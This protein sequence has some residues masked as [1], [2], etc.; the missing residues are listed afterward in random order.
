MNEWVISV[1]QLNEYVRKQ[2]AV[3][4]VLNGL[5]VRGELS[6]FKRYPSGHMYFSLKDDGALNAY[7]PLPSLVPG[8]QPRQEDSLPLARLASDGA[9]ASVQ[10]SPAAPTTVQASAASEGTPT[11]TLVLWGVL[12]V[13][14][15]LLGAMAW[16]LARQT[17]GRTPPAE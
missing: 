2:L 14:V 3:D 4:P 7:L 6:G 8:Y 5:T 13:G 12:L 15:V 16:A 1:S 11:R 9:P 10:P 17:R